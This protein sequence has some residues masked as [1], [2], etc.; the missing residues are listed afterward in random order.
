ML[1]LQEVLQCMKRFDS[2]LKDLQVAYDHK[3]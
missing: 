3:F 2:A 1:L